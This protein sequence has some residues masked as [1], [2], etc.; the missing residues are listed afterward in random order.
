MSY[1]QADKSKLGAA[2]ARNDEK[3]AHGAV[4][5]LLSPG[6]CLLMASLFSK[7]IYIGTQR[8]Y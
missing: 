3:R 2:P 7:R 6:A 1:H 5:I 4:G 8:K